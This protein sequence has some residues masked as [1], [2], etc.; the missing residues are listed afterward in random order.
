MINENDNIRDRNE[1]ISKMKS[2]IQVSKNILEMIETNTTI[3]ELHKYPII[4]AM[5]KNIASQEARLNEYRTTK[6]T[7]ALK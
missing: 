7:D 3:G 2:D 1:L 5:L 4:Q 6:S